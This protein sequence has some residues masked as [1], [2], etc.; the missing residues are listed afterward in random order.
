MEVI[1]QVSFQTLIFR[2][3]IWAISCETDHRWVPQSPFDD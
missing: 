3:D 2:I 1:L